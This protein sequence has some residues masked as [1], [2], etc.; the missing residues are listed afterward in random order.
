ML[1]RSPQLNAA[2]VEERVAERATRQQLLIGESPP[3]IEV[4]L[5]QAVMERPI[6]GPWVMREQLDSIL[7]AA[8]LPN[9]TVQVLPYEVGA[10]PAL[11]SNFIILAFDGEAPTVVYVEGLVGG[12]YLERPPEI[13]RY[14]QVSEKL[15]GLALSPKDSAA[16]LANVRDT[17]TNNK[18]RHD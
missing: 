14:L 4:V 2:E 18:Y 12:L 10:H 8:E 5:D 7:A 16:L 17:Y 6:G 11:E 15:R 13:E 3:Q 9:V 1:F